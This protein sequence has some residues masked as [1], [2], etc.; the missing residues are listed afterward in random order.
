MNA[1]PTINFDKKLTCIIRYEGESEHCRHIA[2]YN[3]KYGVLEGSSNPNGLN[4]D[5]GFYKQVF[6]MK[7][8]HKID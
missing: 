5:T 7:D 2:I 4:A 3:K 6:E 8:L 1:D